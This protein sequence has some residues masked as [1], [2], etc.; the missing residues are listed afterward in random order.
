MKY[1]VKEHVIVLPPSNDTAF[2][3]GLVD[4]RTGYIRYVGSRH[5][6]VCQAVPLQVLYAAIAAVRRQDEDRSVFS[7]ADIADAGA[8]WA[9]SNPKQSAHSM[10]QATLTI[11]IATLLL[12]GK[13]Y[14][15]YSSVASSAF[16]DGL[17][18]HSKAL[19]IAK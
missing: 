12:Q 16:L 11:A 5:E 7:I 1:N 15:E 4:P 17:C 2:I 19:Q 3:Y 13:P 8:V 18:S 9:F 6:A 14:F 10:S